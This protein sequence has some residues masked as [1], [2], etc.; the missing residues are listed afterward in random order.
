MR[1]ANTERNSVTVAARAAMQTE[2]TCGPGAWQS[3]HGAMAIAIPNGRT[4]NR[5][6]RMSPTTASFLV[7]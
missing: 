4:S 3:G 2:R 7:K 5:I 1:R 6:N